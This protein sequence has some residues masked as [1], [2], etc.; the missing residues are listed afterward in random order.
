MESESEFASGLRDSG[1][2]FWTH[3]HVK[4]DASKIA[5]QYED[6]RRQTRRKSENTLTFFLSLSVAA[7]SHGISLFFSRVMFNVEES[8]MLSLTCG[9][10]AQSWPP[11]ARSLLPKISFFF[12]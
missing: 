3:G 11:S 7:C 5:K 2:V 9:S 8:K 1:L 12:K 4:D 6:V 10:T